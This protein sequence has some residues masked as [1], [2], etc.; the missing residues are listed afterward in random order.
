MRIAVVGPCS[1]GKSTLV[2][3]LR[4]HGFNAYAVSQEHS[5]ITRLWDH[6]HPDVLVYLH[7]DYETVQTRRGTNW[8]QWIY[9]AQVERLRDA[10]EHA[11][12]VLDTG[13]MTVDDA[14]ARIIEWLRPRP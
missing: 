10:R 3:R 4:E 8:P 7:I 2:S 6:Q 11:A 13:I 12:I 9:D 1:S 5:I 14:V